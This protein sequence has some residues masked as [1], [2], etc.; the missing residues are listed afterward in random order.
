MGTSNW[1]NIPFNVEVLMKIAPQ[2]VL[3]VGVGFGRWGMIVREFCD[4]WYGRVSESAWSV[5]VEGI[6]AFRDNISQYHRAFYNRIYQGDAREIIFTL[7]GPWDVII[8]G[9]VLEHFERE[10][11]EKILSWCLERSDYIMINIPLGGEWPQSDTYENPYERHLSVWVEQDFEKFNL[12]RKAKFLDY[13]GRTFGVFVLSKQDPQNVKESLFSIAPASAIYVQEGA[14]GPSGVYV[15]ALQYRN[16]LLAFELDEI[17][18]SRGYQIVERL[19]RSRASGLLVKLARMVI[20][21]PTLNPRQNQT[22][23]Q[24]KNLRE[25]PV[26]ISRPGPTSNKLSPAWSPE[27][28]AWIE[29]QLANPQPLSVNHPEWRGILAAAKEAFD[30]VYCV[31]D[32]LDEEKGRY[33]AR[34]LL[35]AQPPSVTIQGFPHTYYHLVTSLHKLAPSLPIY[36]IWHGNFLHSKEDYAWES[37]RLVKSFT[38]EGQISKLGF[39]KLG[40]AEVMKTTG[41]PA[42]FILNFVRYIPESSSLPLSGGNHIGVWAEPDYG[43]KKLPYAMLAAL[44]LI[45]DPVPHV[46]NVSPRAQIFGEWFKLNADYHIDALPRHR[47]MEMLSRM[48][49]NLYV[50]LTECA[51]MLPLESLSLGSPALLGP[52]T[53]YFLD[54]EYL[55]SRLVVP[56]PDNPEVIARRAIQ[57]L[58][59][60]DE[61][62]RAYTSYAPEYNRRALKVLSEFLE[63]PMR[64]A[65]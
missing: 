16:E 53:H 33:Y 59:E 4:V 65:E 43:W 47:A 31:P 6:E 34:L 36:A 51:P 61:I 12:V 9:D 19:R 21:R 63:Y 14:E 49:L 32:D 64:T 28:Q 11:A 22:I 55:H 27:E 56:Y 41:M 17:K 35:E 13:Q 44:S 26:E 25:P 50:S 20:H 1:Q 45:P 23:P 37:F 10:T 62:I 15:Q 29:Q 5:Y 42:Y 54:N 60:R 2:R 24:G 40:M 3:D 7:E 52:T 46:V 18:N 30:N 48:H 58:Q 39:V 38:E 8:F 57:A